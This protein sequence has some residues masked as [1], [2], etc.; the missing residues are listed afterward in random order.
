MMKH[1]W[2]VFGSTVPARQENIREKGG[3]KETKNSENTQDIKQEGEKMWKA[4]KRE[5]CWLSRSEEPV[6]FYESY[7]AFGTL[8]RLF[9]QT[10]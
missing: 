10:N 4:G 1:V 2:M 7:N 9:N 6:L 3:H 5:M 8:S